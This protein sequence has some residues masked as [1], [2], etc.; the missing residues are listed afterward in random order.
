M[1]GDETDLDELRGAIVGDPQRKVNVKTPKN[2]QTND[3][4]PKGM[5]K[6]LILRDEKNLE[7]YIEL[8]YNPTTWPFE[9]TIEFNDKNIVGGDDAIEFKGI[10]RAEFTLE[11][12]F[13]DFGY[14]GTKQG[15]KDSV[16]GKLNWLDSHSDPGLVFYE[17][18]GMVQTPP[19]IFL[20]KGLEAMRVVMTKIS[21][22]HELMDSFFSPVRTKVS[23]TFRKVI[24]P[25]DRSKKGQSWRD[26]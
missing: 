23:V 16:T 10:Q 1:P 11:F 14:H 8:D 21:G 25:R 2:V 19:I 24:R 4:Q 17:D 13:T 15:Y 20:E 26:G 6:K 22:V 18:E 9:K 3:R 7:D 5:G 12:F